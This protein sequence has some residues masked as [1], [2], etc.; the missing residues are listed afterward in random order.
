MKQLSAASFFRLP[1]LGILMIFLAGCSVFDP[2]EEIPSYLHIDSMTL[3]AIGSQQGSSSSNITDAWIYM[4]GELIGGF[5]LP[6]TVPILA[7]GTHHFIIRGGVKMNG[8]AATRAIYPFYKG[9][10]GDITLTRAQKTDV[11][12]LVVEYFTGNFPAVWMEDFDGAGFSITSDAQYNA[13]MRRRTGTDALEGNY[14]YAILDADST[15]IIARSSNS[16]PLDATGE[17]WLEVNYKCNQ[18]FSIG[19]VGNANDFHEWLVVSPN[20]SWNKVYIRLTD[21]IADTPSTSPYQI[22][23][24]MNNGSN[25]QSY[26]YL[27]NIKLLK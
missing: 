12:N 18:S 17:V 15:N 8:L 20:E 7:E 24:A 11:D 3:N 27:D 13:S 10:E 16:F 14:G 22:Y 25:S 2:A 5:E 6:C 1:A 4:D 21:A 9:W 23:F 26:L 19:L